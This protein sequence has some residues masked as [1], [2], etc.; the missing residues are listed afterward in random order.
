MLGVVDLAKDPFCQRSLLPRI[1]FAKGRSVGRFSNLDY[2]KANLPG[3]RFV[4]SVVG[5]RLVNSVP[6]GWVA[7]LVEGTSLEN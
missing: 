1:P 5:K 7:E 6:T 2:R 3:F 4:G